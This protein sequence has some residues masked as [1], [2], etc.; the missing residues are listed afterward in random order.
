M[1]PQWKK[2]R[3]GDHLTDAELKAMLKQINEALPYLE[4]RGAEFLLATR[5]TR[6]N[7][8]T[9]EGYLSARVLGK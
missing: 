2:F 8:I 7:K 4:S 3:N 6:Q 9:I 1:N 5:E